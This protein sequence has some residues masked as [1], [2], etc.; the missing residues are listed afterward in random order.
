MEKTDWF[1]ETEKD[2]IVTN[3]VLF[4]YDENEKQEQEIDKTNAKLI[5]SPKFI[6]IYP[7]LLDRLTLTEAL[8]FWFIDFYKSNSSDRMYFTNEQLGKILHCSSDTASRSIISLEKQWYIK[9]SRK[10]RAWWGQIRFITDILHSSNY[11]NCL[12]ATSENLQTNNN[13]INDNKINIYSDK[14][15]TSIINILNDKQ[16]EELRWLDILQEFVNYWGETNS[17][18]KEKRQLQKTRDLNKRLAIRK[19]NK[20]TNFWRKQ[21]IDYTILEN[22]DK[23]IR[24]NLDEVKNFFK[25]KYWQYWQEEYS[26]KKSERKHSPLVFNP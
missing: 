2:W 20:Q 6:P 26:K 10:M 3:Q 15:T 7:N 22:F 1:I 16:M 9:T 21:I 25:N 13:K 8:L 4:T 18:W 17:R 12:V 24:T 23:W 11:T 5:F 19:K 14:K